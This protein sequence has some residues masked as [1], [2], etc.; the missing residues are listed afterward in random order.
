MPTI[1]TL[2]TVVIV[3]EV[4]SSSLSY[5]S[6][7]LTRLQLCNISLFTLLLAT[8][9]PKHSMVTALIISCLLRS[10]LDIAPPIVHKLVP[11][12]LGDHLQQF[13]AMVSFCVANSIL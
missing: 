4:Y 12:Q 9:A 5:L 1:G 6:L 8:P 13:E 3:L 11:Q 10:I 2:T 7:V